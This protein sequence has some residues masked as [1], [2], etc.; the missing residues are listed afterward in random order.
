MSVQV[1]KDRI[2]V[3]LDNQNSTTIYLHGATI[4][5]WVCNGKERLFLSKKAVLNGSKAIRG[6]IPLVF[7]Q[8]G[9]GKAFPNLQHGFARILSWEYLGIVEQTQNITVRF[10]L[11]NDEN[12]ITSEWPF[13]FILHYDVQLSASSLTSKVEVINNGNVKFNFHFLLHTYLKISSIENVEV[14]GLENIKFTNKLDGKEYCSDGSI[15]INQEVDRVYPTTP[16]KLII[17]EKNKLNGDEIVVVEKNSEFCDVVVWNPWIEKSL[18]MNDFDP[19][20]YKEMIC[21]EVG[22][23]TELFDLSPG[24]VWKAQQCLLIKNTKSNF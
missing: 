9:L 12:N 15:R 23:V 8:F 6:G 5:S 22:K 16:N 1:E 2:V 17:T 7:P 11:V 3:S 18:K 14:S 21:V 20:E 24:K 4:T 13:N 19:N 10:K